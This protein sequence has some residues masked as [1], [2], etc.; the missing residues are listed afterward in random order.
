MRTPRRSRLVL[1]TVGVAALCLLGQGIAVGFVGADDTPTAGAG[2]FEMHRG[3]SLTMGERLPTGGA[4][5]AGVEPATKAG[6][7]L[8]GPAKGAAEPRLTP[9]TAGWNTLMTETFEGAWPNGL[10]STFDNNGSTGGAVFWD[11]EN[12]IA[13]SG[14]WSGW[15]AGGGANGLDPNFDFYANDM[16]SWAVYGPFDLSGYPYAELDFWYWNRS[17]SGFDPFYWA[18][19][20]DGGSFVGDF[21]WGDSGGWQ[22]VEFDLS[23]YLGDTD[24]WIAFI[25][26]SDSTNTWDGPFVDDVALGAGVPNDDFGS[27]TVIGGVPYT[28]TQDVAQATTALDDPSFDPCLTPGYGQRYGSVWYA[29]TAPNSYVATVDTIGSDYDTILGVWTGSPGS[30]SPVACNDDS[31]S[32]GIL[33]SWTQFNL[34]TGT[35]YYI[36]VASFNPGP[37]PANLTLNMTTTP[38]I[39]EESFRSVG[40]YDGWV[41]EEDEASAKGGTFDS[42]AT[43]GRL[44]DDSLDRQYRSILDFD[45]SSLPDGAVVVGVTLRIKRQAISGTNPFTTHG[46][47]TVD[48]KTGFYH[49]NSAL[50]KFDFHAV[51]SRG[52]VG[53]FIK[54]PAL[55]WYRAPLRAP[56]YALVNLTGHTQ[57]RLRFA[58]DDN[59]DFGDDYLAFFTGNAPV[60]TDR[61]ELI[62][63]YYVP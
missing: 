8:S 38:L 43:T 1:V 54:T 20:G 59:D 55:G 45:T 5:V 26:Q 50:E 32:G 25:F 17:E 21:V 16:D 22:H 18:A 6:S 31:P 14:Y 33:Q 28:R 37:S 10:W 53:R 57:F 27:A 48:Q 13:H 19:S 61:P 62:V 35:T 2:A 40:A 3:V 41:L 51:G 34:S 36:E 15:P 63:S 7:P 29:Y 11:D 4:K 24:V 60:E 58:V 42:T 52:N 49:E 46:Y 12:W 23:G 39:V 56:S 9:R 47:L 30:L 44:G